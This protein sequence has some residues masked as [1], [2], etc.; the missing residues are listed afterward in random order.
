M[1]KDRTT[2]HFDPNVPA[3]FAADDGAI[4]V[5]SRDSAAHFGKQHRN[6]L[7]KIDQKIAEIAKLEAE[8]G[9]LKSEQTPMPV[10][11][12]VK[13]VDEQNGEEYR[14]FEMDRRAHS[15]IV[16]G[17]TG[18]KALKWQ[19]DYINTFER[20]EAER[21]Q[22]SRMTREDVRLMIRE[23]IASGGKEVVRL[24]KGAAWGMVSGQ[25]AK[26]DRHFNRVHEDS[27]AIFSEVSDGFRE[28]HDDIAETRLIS[29]KHLLADQHV[30]SMPGFVTR[31]S[32]KLRV[33]CVDNSRRHR[34]SPETKVYFYDLTAARDWLKAEGQAIIDAKMVG[35]KAE[36]KVAR[37]AAEDASRGQGNLNLVELRPKKPAS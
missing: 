32:N 29:A 36:E 2:S 6:V 20:M 34:R 5:D 23:E 9:V 10:F 24:I 8:G 1:I 26:A 21:R 37:K 4:I 17:F 33:F 28:V 19:I 22:P 13:S 25:G 30:P 3:V 7:R 14:S 16:L 31:I 35:K 15:L 11:R 12:E 18:E 27:A